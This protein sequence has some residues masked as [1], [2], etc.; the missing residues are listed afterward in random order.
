MVPTANGA[1]RNG[2]AV[3]VPRL[4]HHLGEVPGDKADPSGRQTFWSRTLA[5]NHSATTRRRID[6]CAPRNAAREPRGGRL[7]G[8]GAATGQWTRALEQ[9][10]LASRRG[11]RR[12]RPRQQRLKEPWLRAG[13]DSRGLIFCSQRTL[14]FR[15]VNSSGTELSS[16]DNE[17]CLGGVPWLALGSIE[18]EEREAYREHAAGYKVSV[19]F[20]A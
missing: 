4:R 5:G 14:E 6:S 11:E 2:A 19:V 13:L 1:D 8:D 7:G 3:I 9:G 20:V 10:R 15:I 16:G 12:R 18:V 17:L